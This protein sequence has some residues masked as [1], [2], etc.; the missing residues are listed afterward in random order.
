MDPII[1]FFLLGLAAGLLRSELRL[2]GAVYEL[3]SM[4]LLLAIGLKGGM[5]LA[6]QA[7]GPLALQVAP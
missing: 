7:F 1:L 2:P 3:I 6:Q 5:E 4:L